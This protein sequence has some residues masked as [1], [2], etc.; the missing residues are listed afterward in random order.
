MASRLATAPVA[1]SLD[2]W[3]NRRVYIRRPGGAHTTTRLAPAT[4]RPRQARIQDISVG[5]VALISRQHLRVGT[6]LLIRVKNEDL[7]IAY[8]LSARVVHAT[9]KTRAQWVLGCKFARA[10]S[11][12]ELETLL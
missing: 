5:G 2:H 3:S 9:A 8:D 1:S 10:L 4:A 11:E 12:P 7:G 6:R